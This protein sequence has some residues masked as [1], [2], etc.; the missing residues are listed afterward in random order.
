MSDVTNTSANANGA[1]LTRT[2]Y[3]FS[4]IT[5]SKGTLEE[6]KELLEKKIKP[7]L[8][9]YANNPVVID[10]SNVNYLNTIDFKAMQ[11]LCREYSLFLLGLSG[12]LTEERAQ[13]LNRLDIPVVNSSKFA[14]IR[15]ENFKPRVITKTVEIK[16][17]VQIKVPFEVRIA[18]PLLV[19]DHNVRSGELISAPDN[20][21]IVFG[22][23]AST[24]RI[25]ASHN[26]I[27][28]GDLHGE[29]FAG[30]P[31]DQQKQGYEQAFIYVNGLF[32]P[33]LVAIAG[34]YQTADDLECN[35]NMKDIY[36]KK[37]ALKVSLNGKNLNYC[38]LNVL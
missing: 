26:I 8:D 31:K 32:N 18:E 7:A 10:V 27:V 15:E 3:S 23:V 9:L 33:N 16:V 1:S 14:R 34:Q 30:S 5:L 25:I 22:N 38:P 21:V 2:G 37:G 24:A 17:P 4:T 36:G 11:S 6:L 13:T 12:V 19:I 20:S 28:L 35:Q 29:V